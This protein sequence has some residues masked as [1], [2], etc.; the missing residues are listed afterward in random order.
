MS[1][2]K[3]V[4]LIESLLIIVFAGIIVLLLANIPNALGLINK[5]SHLSLAKEIATKQVEDKRGISYANLS[6]DNSPIVDSRINLL[7]SGSGN[8]VV[9]DCNASICTNG[10]HIKQLVVT[11]SWKENNKNQTFTLKTFIGEGGINQ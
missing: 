9:E 7:P 11:I 4:S 1:S 5:S 10:E 2:Q 6:N 3:G 8:V